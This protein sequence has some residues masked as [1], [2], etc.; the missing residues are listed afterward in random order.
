MNPD[1]NA[2]TPPVT[3]PPEPTPPPVEPAP[4][5]PDTNPTTL[6]NQP[7]AGYQGD[8]IRPTGILSQDSPLRMKTGEAQSTSPSAPGKVLGIVSFILSLVG[9]GIVSIVLGIIAMVQS[10]KAGR[11]NGFALASIIIGAVSVVVVGIIWAVLFVTAANLE[12]QCRQ[13]GP[14][15]YMSGDTMLTCNADGSATLSNA[16]NMQ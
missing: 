7:A 5:H 4:T 1:Q 10:K 12:S 8:F 13:R 3:P 14:G 15:M 2:P 6:T 11:K 16:A 9:G